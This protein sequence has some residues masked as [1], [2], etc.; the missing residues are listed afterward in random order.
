M[1][2]RSVVRASVRRTTPFTPARF[3]STT[4]EKATEAAKDAASKAA[5]GL[6]RV[7]SAAG[8]AISGAAKG[9]AGALGKVGGRTGKVVNF[10]ERQTP[11]VV[12]YS[13]VAAEVAKIVFR[14]QKMSPPSAATFQSFYESAWQSIRQPSK[15]ADTVAQ[16][17]KSGAQKPAGYIPGISNAQLAAGGVVLA[18][19]LGFF[20]VGEI[21]G[22]FKL[23]GYHGEPAA[24][25]H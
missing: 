24:A 19:C 23:V 3:Q 2:S 21:I 9:V 13:K 8:P 7:T 11:F 25:H 17:V 15:I 1:L 22:R 10:L 12:Y 18:E 16:T 20:T 4:T 6:S 5:Q 14:G